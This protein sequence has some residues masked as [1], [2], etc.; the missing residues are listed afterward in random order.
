MGAGE[1]F[2]AGSATLKTVDKQGLTVSTQA[3]AGGE[4]VAVV[5]VVVVAVHHGGDLGV[6]AVLLLQ[7][8]LLLQPSLP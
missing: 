7:G 2:G 8:D 4:V 6:L 1:G 3:A 5:V